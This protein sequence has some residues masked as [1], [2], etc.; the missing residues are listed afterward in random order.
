[1][2]TTDGFWIWRFPRDGK[3][4][5]IGM[6]GLGALNAPVAGA[7][8]IRW[9]MKCADNARSDGRPLIARDEEGNLIAVAAPVGTPRFRG[10]G[11]KDEAA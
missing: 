10:E 7:A 4:G 3:L 11:D 8:G 2:V 5:G 9:G 6:A 1:M